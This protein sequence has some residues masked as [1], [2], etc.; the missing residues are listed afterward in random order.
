MKINDDSFKITNI[1]FHVPAEHLIDGKRYDLE[2]HIYGSTESGKELESAVFFK[3]GDENDF[4]QDVI[5]ST[6][7]EESKTFTLS[8]VYDEGELDNYY[9]YIGSVSAPFPDC[10]ENNP[11]V[12]LEDV[13]EASS[14]QIA[15]FAEV[16]AETATYDNDGRYRNV[17][18]LNGRKVY[19]YSEDDDDSSLY[20]TLSSLLIAFFLI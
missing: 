12:L 5:D 17:Q 10:N 11:W 13:Q 18:P 15:Y 9:Y 16:W 8:D 1:H 7:N 2:L 3:E 4:I 6:E 14:E 19:L 20:L